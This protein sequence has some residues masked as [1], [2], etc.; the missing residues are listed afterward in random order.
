VEL[1]KLGNGAFPIAASLMVIFATMTNSIAGSLNALR[2]VMRAS[3]VSFMQG[4]AEGIKSASYLVVMAAIVAA[5]AVENAFRNATQTHS[6]SL[7]YKAIGADLMAGLEQGIKGGSPAA[8]GAMEGSLSGAIPRVGSGTGS[9][10]GGGNFTYSPQ[11]TVAINGSGLS[12]DEL[13]SAMANAFNQH[14]AKLMQIVKQ[15]S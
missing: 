5:N 7:L 3:G 6:P 4:L 8:V 11:Y 12:P 2:N 15:H 10:S 14:D 1:Q 9:P 13:Q